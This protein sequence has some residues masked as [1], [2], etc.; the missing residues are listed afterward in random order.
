MSLGELVKDDL[1]N[2][3]DAMS[4]IEILDPKMDLG[5]QIFDD[6]LTLAELVKVRFIKVY[7]REESNFNLFIEWKN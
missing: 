2:L 3:L 7:F 1:F 6:K 4:A 5:M